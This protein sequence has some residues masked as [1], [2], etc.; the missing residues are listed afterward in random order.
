MKQ[1]VFHF[2]ER[3]QR[4]TPDDRFKGIAVG[5]TQDESA[6]AE[7]AAGN[8]WANF[9][10]ETAVFRRQSDGSYHVDKTALLR[11]SDLAVS[12][13]FVE[14]D[15]IVWFARDD[16]L[17]RY[18]PSV[19]KNYSADYPALIRRVTVGDERVLFGGALTDGG[20]APQLV[21]AATTRSGSSSPPQATTM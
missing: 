4:F 21:S 12:K 13:I 15:G 10:K 16:G 20:P 18:D 6:I 14:P 3:S 11:F 17:V 7:D 2:D 1:G 8:V 19:R 5:G 9:G